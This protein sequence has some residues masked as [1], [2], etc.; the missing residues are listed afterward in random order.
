MVTQHCRALIGNIVSDVV[1]S[2]RG[3]QL[4]ALYRTVNELQ[5]AT[6]KQKEVVHKLTVAVPSLQ[7]AVHDQQSRYELRSLTHWFLSHGRSLQSCAL[8][9]LPD[10]AL[11][12]V[13]GGG[14][15]SPAQ[16]S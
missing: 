1:G 14:C 15:G 6:T 9:M 3:H 11:G 4:E 7:A 2:H 12:G 10:C 5:V 8:R 16:T 13:A